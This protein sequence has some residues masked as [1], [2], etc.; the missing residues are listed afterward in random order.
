MNAGAHDLLRERKAPERGD[1]PLDRLARAV[2]HGL[3]A[4]VTLKFPLGGAGETR[5]MVDQ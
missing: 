1:V 5:E 3:G 4:T 2:V